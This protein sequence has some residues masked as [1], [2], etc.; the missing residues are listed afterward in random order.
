M[1]EAAG[2]DE[3]FWSIVDSSAQFEADPEKQLAALRISLAAQRP[4]DLV[5]PGRAFNAQLARSYTW[6]L[7]GAAYVLHGGASDDGFE[8]FRR[9]LVSKGRRVFETV[10]A[11]P[12]SLADLLAPDVEG[13][14]EFEEFAY[15]AVEVWEDRMGSEPFPQ[16]GAFPGGAPSGT[17]FEETM[18]HLSA[19]Y[20]RL[21][22]RF[23]DAPLG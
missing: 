9:W 10:L 17:P 19:R 6:D 4:E 14:C 12:D 22:A 8:Y 16:T 3:R 20:P 15:V 1:S 23:G 5:E 18:E 21:W 7:W 13:P 11:T 2:P